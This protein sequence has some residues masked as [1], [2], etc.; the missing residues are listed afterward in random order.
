MIDPNPQLRLIPHWNHGHRLSLESS[1][2]RAV[3]GEGANDT[4]IL[5]VVVDAQFLSE[6]RRS[7]GQYGV[8]VPARLR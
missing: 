5:T 8:G 4:K 7:A 6:K 2:L 1:D 3:G